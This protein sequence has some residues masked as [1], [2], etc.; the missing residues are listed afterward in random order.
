LW[1]PR[2]L[3]RQQYLP[4]VAVFVVGFEVADLFT[5][6]MS[7]PT[8]A[9]A[10]LGHPV[11]VTSAGWQRMN[12]TDPVGAI[13]PGAFVTTAVSVTIEPAGT[14]L[15]GFE[16]LVNVTSPFSI[17]ISVEPDAAAKSSDTTPT[18]VARV[19]GT[20]VKSGRPEAGLAGTA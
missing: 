18:T 13:A 10:G 6:G 3:A 4:N 12:L 9:P 8:F 5:N 17:A 14:L 20:V 1:S 11:A 16:V 19:R 2:Y 15:F 7:T